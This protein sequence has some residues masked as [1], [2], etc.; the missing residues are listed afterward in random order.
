MLGEFSHFFQP[1]NM[2]S[3]HR[4]GFFWRKKR[5]GITNCHIFQIINL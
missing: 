2:N 5:M 1:K 3:T 4:K